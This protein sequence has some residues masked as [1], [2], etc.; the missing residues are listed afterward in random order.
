MK[1]TSSLSVF[2]L[3]AVALVSGVKSAPAEAQADDPAVKAGEQLD[4]LRDQVQRYESPIVHAFL[5]RAALGA[6]ISGENEKTHTIVKFLH[7]QDAFPVPDAQ[8]AIWLRTKTGEVFSSKTY[9]NAVWFVTPVRLS[10]NAVLDHGE[11]GKDDFPTGRRPQDPVNLVT[12]FTKQWSEYKEDIALD[13]SSVAL[14][15]ASLYNL[16]SA[17][18]L[19]GYEIG[20]AKFQWK[21]EEFCNILT[22]NADSATIE[23]KVTDA[24]TDHQQEVR[25]LYRVQQKAKALSKIFSKDP[26]Y[27]DN[28]RDSILR[29][30]QAYLIPITTAIETQTVLDQAPHCK[31]YKAPKN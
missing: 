21:N 8:V 22:S 20:L 19:L 2:V 9:P 15:D 4:K 17:R 23:Q 14:L 7:G 26:A 10:N 27:P 31:N 18:M 30:F 28:T 5:A 29:L 13:P 24:L 11:V 3:A 16:V 25:V 6:S 1:I 12:F